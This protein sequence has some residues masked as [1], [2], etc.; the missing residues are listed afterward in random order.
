[1]EAR[2]LLALG[3]RRR[4]GR[5]RVPARDTALP[6]RG[7]RAVWKAGEP[8]I[9]SI[10]GF[11]TALGW[12]ALAWR[13]GR[14]TRITFGHASAKAALEAAAAQVTPARTA[15]A[16][17]P[18]VHGLSLANA[19]AFIG[20]LAERLRNYAD[21]GSGDFSDVPLDLDH[22]TTFQRRVTGACRRIAVGRTATY[23][24]LAR[25]VGSAGAARAVGSVMASN[26]F[27]LVVPCHRVVASGSLGGFSA[28]NGLAMKRRLLAL[29]QRTG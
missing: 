28:P 27:P 23:G 29:E 6:H 15:S 11:S 9:E 10:G 14:V 25:Q 20:E 3:K 22:L 1:M 19:P 4:G 8:G 18:S 17:L 5:S 7:H 13:D 24:E 21:D 26:R 2:D 12:M 16:R